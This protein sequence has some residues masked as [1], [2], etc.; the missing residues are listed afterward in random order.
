MTSRPDREVLIAR[1][2]DGEATADDWQAIRDLAA[3]DQTIWSDLAESQSN[4]DQ[5]RAAVGEL[6]AVADTIEA[7][8]REHAA[9]SLTHRLSWV[10]RWGGWAVAAAVL[11]AWSA[12]LL[13]VPQSSTGA[14]AGLGRSIEPVSL[15]ADQAL[16]AYLDQG[17]ASGR[18][19][20]Q[21]PEL[22]VLESRPVENGTGYEI[23]YLRQIVER[24]IIHDLYRVSEDETGR[25]IPIPIK[26][27]PVPGKPL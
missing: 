26:R 13:G 1:V 24:A 2:I 7:P 22:V 20:R 21:Q 15:T 5:L 19:V 9:V 12:G 8:I 11:L 4:H 27:L 6:L 14:R 16:Q 17:R 10:G 25:I 18:I 23:I 3:S